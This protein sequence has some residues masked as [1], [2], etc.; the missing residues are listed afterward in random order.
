MW[1]VVSAVP[2]GRETEKDSAVWHT[3]HEG[4]EYTEKYD[5][6]DMYVG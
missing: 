3:G 5:W 1:S 2:K 6:G 4:Q